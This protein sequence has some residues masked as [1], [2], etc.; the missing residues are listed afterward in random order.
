MSASTL[1]KSFVPEAW[2]PALRRQ[3][4]RARHFGWRRHCNVCASH[5][6]GFL[7][8]GAPSEPDFL[9]PVCRSKPPHRLAA[10]YFDTHPDVFT[11]DGVFVHIAPEPGLK[12][13]L[14]RKTERVGMQY[15]WGGITGVGEHRLD[16]LDLPFEDGTVDAMYCC[17]VL[18]C[19]QEDRAAMLEVRRVV[20]PGGVA[21]LQVPAFFAGAT[22]LETNG[23]QERLAAFADEGI[24]RCY[25]NEDYEAR[26]RESGFHAEAF[27]AS[28]LV[29]VLVARQALK[30][31]VLHVCRPVGP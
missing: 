5:L 28:A 31:E 3:Y 12:Q 21:L 10:V 1:V 4:E 11:R 16:L 29:P 6:G 30:Q 13:M 14:Q 24:F 2:R 7:A 18:N 22:T 26:L 25:T 23:L 9:C 20:R 17:H 15:R 8:H 19:L 27:R